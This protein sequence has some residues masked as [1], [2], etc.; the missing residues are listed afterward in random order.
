MVK[1]PVDAPKRKVVKTLEISWL[2]NCKGERA[3]FHG[4]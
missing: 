3:N 4:M 2:L 1:F